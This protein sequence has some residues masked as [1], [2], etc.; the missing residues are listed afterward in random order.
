M[1][2]KKS[3]RSLIMFPSGSRHS[4]DVKG[5]VALIAKNGK[6]PYHAGYLHRSH[7]FEGLS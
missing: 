4:N 3:D 1:F 5:G 7:D 6:G 2:S